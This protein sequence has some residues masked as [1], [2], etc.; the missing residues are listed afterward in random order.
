MRFRTSRI[1][2]VCAVSAL[3]IGVFAGGAFAAQ[4][5]LTLKADHF[6]FNKT[7]LTAK[8]GTVSITMTNLE[9][10]GHNVAIKKGS[11]VIKKG[12]VVTKGKKSIVTTIL[13]KG[14]YTFYCSVP[15]HEAAMHGTLTVK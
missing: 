11:K 1:V 9:S 15:G 13:K 12:K 10:L 6:A 14:S 3:G 2:T 7:A 8:A 5:K 4:S